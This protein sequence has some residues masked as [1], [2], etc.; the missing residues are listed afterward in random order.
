MQGQDVLRSVAD[1]GQRPLHLQLPID[2]GRRARAECG[3]N[4]GVMVA[5]DWDRVG[6]VHPGQIDNQRALIRNRHQTAS[7]EQNRHGRP[8]SRPGGS[9]LN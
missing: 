5:D 7:V 8:G 3:V 2:D 6:D 1:S 4:R 9:D